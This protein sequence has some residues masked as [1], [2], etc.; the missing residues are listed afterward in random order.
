MYKINNNY[1]SS[2]HSFIFVFASE[3]L[4]IKNVSDIHI[5]G[6]HYLNINVDSKISL[7]ITCYELY[8]SSY[9]PPTLRTALRKTDETIRGLR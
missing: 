4:A 3:M 7:I 5:S 1:L 9:V 6:L 2:S 8:L